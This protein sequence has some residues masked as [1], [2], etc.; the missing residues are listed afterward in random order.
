VVKLNLMRRSEGEAVDGSRVISVL[1]G[2]GG[3]GRT[4]LAYNLACLMAEARL[5]VLLVDAD[6]TSGNLHIVGN[7]ACDGTVH[8][9]LSDE[10]GRIESV[11][12]SVQHRVDLLPSV[13][14]GQSMT[15]FDTSSA[16]R[17]ISMLRSQAAE[18]DVIVIDH[19]SAINE[20]VAL[21]ANA[22][23]INLLVMIPELTSIT[24][25]YALYRFLTASGGNVD[26]RIL[27]N[28]A[29]SADEAVYIQSKL[30]AMTER[31]LGRIPEFAGFVTENPIF[32]QALAA[33]L[34]IAAID[35]KSQVTQELTEIAQQLT[36]GLKRVSRLNLSSL[37]GSVKTGPETADVKG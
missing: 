15:S 5:R 37:V 25:C 19:G 9:L 11:V 12:A 10:S 28:R 13:W 14:S 4:M 33:Q 8:D 16:A 17:L 1:S 7:V 22:S 6:L 24:D 2:K 32:R 27:L 35:G 36:G 3:V 29:E 23:D 31:F 26:C 18:Y 30:S 34:P 20:A 21:L